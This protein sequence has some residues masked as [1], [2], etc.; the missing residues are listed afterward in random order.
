MQNLESH[1]SDA[2]RLTLSCDSIFV[3]SQ[4]RESE[5]KLL[6]ALIERFQQLSSAIELTT[7]QSS[8]VVR[9]HDYKELVERQIQWLSEIEEKVRED[10]PLDDIESVRNLLSEQQVWNIH[11]FIGIMFFASCEGCYKTI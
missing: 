3:G 2:E 9:C 10:V 5:S 4:Q 7:S 8:T 6:A 11:S 1:Q